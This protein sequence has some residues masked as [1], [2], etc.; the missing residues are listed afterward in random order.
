MAPP[1]AARNPGSSKERHQE[2]RFGAYKHG[3]VRRIDCWPARLSAEAGS[4]ERLIKMSTLLLPTTPDQLTPAALT[5]LIGEL[6]SGLEYLNAAIWGVLSVVVALMQLALKLRMSGRSLRT[7]VAELYFSERTDRQRGHFLQRRAT[8]SV[9][10]L[11][12]VEPV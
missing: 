12:G 7:S 3:A 2:D 8:S 11:P 5:D 4:V 6:N 1:N 9:I 10:S